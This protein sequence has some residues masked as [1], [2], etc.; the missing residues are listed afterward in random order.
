MPDNIYILFCT[1]KTLQKGIEDMISCELSLQEGKESCK[2][3]LYYFS[4]CIIQK[5]NT[6]YSWI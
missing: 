4:S 5:K 1:W 2:W 6:S 3:K